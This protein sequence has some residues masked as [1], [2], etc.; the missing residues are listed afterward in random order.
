MV[1]RD[2]ICMDFSKNNQDYLYLGTSSGDFLAIQIK[3]KG[4]SALVT[5][6]SQGKFFYFN[7]RCH[8][9]LEFTQSSIIGWLW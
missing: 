4:L 3:N 5:V 6:A 9:Y 8:S 2:Y 7:L 1:V